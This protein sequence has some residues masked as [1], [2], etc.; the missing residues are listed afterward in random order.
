M[1]GAAVRGGVATRGRDRLYIIC[2]V[3]LSLSI[4]CNSAFASTSVSLRRRRSRPS[5]SQPR[6]SSRRTALIRSL[7]HD[8]LA[9]FQAASFPHAGGGRY[10][11]GCSNGDSDNADTGEAGLALWGATPCC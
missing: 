2:Q 1:D 9:P 6:R 5:L 4:H 7:S 11:E 10:S 3:R 8:A